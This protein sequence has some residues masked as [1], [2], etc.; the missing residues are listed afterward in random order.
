MLPFLLGAM[1]LVVLFA[2]AMPAAQRKQRL[3]AVQRELVERYR[4]EARRH[5]RLTA[6]V[7]AL[8]SDPFF[9]ERAYAETWCVAPPGARA[10]D[11]VVRSEPAPVE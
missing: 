1:T 6:T 3:R 11:A 8:R 9:I 5:E 10:L 2:N 7:H 4:A